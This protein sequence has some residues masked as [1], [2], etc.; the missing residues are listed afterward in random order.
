VRGVPGVG[1]FNH[2]AETGI[3]V[4]DNSTRVNLRICISASLL[5][6]NQV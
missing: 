6:N 2:C 3:M 5:L 4:L 1:K